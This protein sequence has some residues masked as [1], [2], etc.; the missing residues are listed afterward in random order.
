MY[1][2]NIRYKR[3]L[4]HKDIFYLTAICFSLVHPAILLKRMKRLRFNLE[5]FK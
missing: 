1:S 2:Y 5:Y 3:F 4:I